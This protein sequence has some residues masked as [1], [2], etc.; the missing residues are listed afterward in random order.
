MFTYA[1]LPY[2]VLCLFFCWFGGLGDIR[3]A[4][5]AAAAAAAVSSSSRS[6]LQKAKRI[7]EYEYDLKLQ[8]DLYTSRYETLSHTMTHH[9]DASL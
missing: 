7:G 1:D 5:A 4:S 9:Y 6:L 2:H 3:I 8:N